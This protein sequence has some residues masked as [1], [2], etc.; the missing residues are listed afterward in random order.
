AT[1]LVRMCRTL[2]GQQITPVRVRLSHHRRDINP[3]FI[4]FFGSDIEFSA[5]AD[6]I[7]FAAPAS[8]LPTVSADPY[9]HKL[10]PKNGESAL[11]R[12][13][14]NRGSLRSIVENV[15]VPLLPHG[16]AQAAE[17]AGRLGMSQRTFARRL[18]A[19]GVTFSQ[20]LESLRSHLAE[21]YLAD[22]SLS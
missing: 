12:L 21:R 8:V 5:A 13:T 16:Q 18:A 11:P 22:D 19:E 14:A 1:V 6:D 7:T 20:V 2:T 4:E 3:A 10:L 9:L 17:V 15:L